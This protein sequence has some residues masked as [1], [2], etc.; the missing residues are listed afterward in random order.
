MKKD[1]DSDK[2]GDS[3]DYAQADRRARVKMALLLLFCWPL[4]IYVNLKF[5][6][7]KRH[8]NLGDEDTA[9][10]CAEQISRVGFKHVLLTYLIMIGVFTLIVAV[11]CAV[12]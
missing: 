3:F 6:K 5:M 2:S 1:S 10:Q 12:C 8:H 4:S 11:A 7:M 9:R